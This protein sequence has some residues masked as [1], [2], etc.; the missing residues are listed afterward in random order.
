MIANP[1]GFWYLVLLA[2]LALLLF[3]RYREGRRDLIRLAGSWRAGEVGNVFVVKWFFSGLAIILFTVFTVLAIT[4]ISWGQYPVSTNYAGTDVSI[5]V[6]ISRSMLAQDL[7][8]SRIKRV[9][10]VLREVVNANTGIRFDVVVFKGTAVE[11]LPA[12]QDTEAM[13]SVA[14]VLGPTMLTTPGTNIEQG[15]RTAVASFPAQ[16]PNRHIVLLFS[17][18]GS[19]SGDPLKAA[20]EAAAQHIP[21]YAVACG[22]ASG[23]PIPIGNGQYVEDSAGNRVITKLDLA[24]LQS[25]AGISGGEVLKLSDPLLARKIDSIIGRHAASGSVGSYRFEIKEQYRVFVVSALLC[26]CVFLAVRII[27]W[28]GI[29]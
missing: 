15:L 13:T 9:S 28:K 23:G 11:V 22:T 6:D 29:V 10:S 7:F 4:G 24:T 16:D 25:V 2:P 8:P 20:R 1:S 21:I 5:A 27:R 17:D 26:L 14:D 19:L 18:G 12:T 3:L